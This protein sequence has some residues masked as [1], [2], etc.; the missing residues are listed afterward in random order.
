M[1]AHSEAQAEAEAVGDKAACNELLA[2]F[3]EH[4]NA[5]AAAPTQLVIG[6]LFTL[7]TTE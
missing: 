4:S 3:A 5:T 7:N 6:K 1:D 2:R